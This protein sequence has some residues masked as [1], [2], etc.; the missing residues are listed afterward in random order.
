MCWVNWKM[1]KDVCQIP[2][3]CRTLERGSNCRGDK[4]S[5]KTKWHPDTCLKATGERVSLSMHMEDLHIPSSE[6]YTGSTTH[7]T[8]STNPFCLLVTLSGNRFSCPSTTGNEF[9]SFPALHLHALLLS[10]F[11]LVGSWQFRRH[12]VLQW[13]PD[14]WSCQARHEMRLKRH[15]KDHT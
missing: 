2:L 7:S 6:T 4:V 12:R 10:P 15:N 14:V 9:G 8:A 1:A 13:K 3:F 11:L 5:A